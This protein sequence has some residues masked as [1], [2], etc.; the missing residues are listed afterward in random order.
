MLRI[1]VK[2]AN[3][4]FSKF[5]YYMSRSPHNQAAFRKFLILRHHGTGRH[6]TVRLDMD[7]VHQNGPHAYQ[8]M[9]V[10][11]AGMQNGIMAHRHI[12]THMHSDSC[13]KVDSRII[14]NIG[15]LAN[16]NLGKISAYYRI[17]KNRRIIANFYIANNFGTFRD[18]HAF[19]ENGLFTLEFNQTSHIYNL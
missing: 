7:T 12:V 17:V 15:S 5:A 4:V 19:A 3:F 16:A 10:H 9:V 11:I 6:Y 1:F 8:H 18:K 14:L 2:F 13:R